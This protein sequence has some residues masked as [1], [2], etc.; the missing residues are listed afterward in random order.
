MLT[1]AARGCKATSAKR[2]ARRALVRAKI[3]YFLS[4]LFLK[5]YNATLI[6]TFYYHRFARNAPAFEQKIIIC[7]AARLLSAFPS[8]RCFNNE[9]FVTV[10]PDPRAARSLRF[11]PSEL[12]SVSFRSNGRRIL[13][14]NEAWG[15][16]PRQIRAREHRRCCCCA[17]RAA[18][19]V[20]CLNYITLNL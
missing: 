5:T 13:S 17:R 6:N 2:R 14:V 19:M 11:S 9:A 12:R 10:L 16:D 20:I 7:R 3:I 4:N 8:D 18:R 15:L 1:H